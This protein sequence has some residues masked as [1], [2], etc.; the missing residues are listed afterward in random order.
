MAG[1]S[2]FDISRFNKRYSELSSEPSTPHSSGSR[3]FSVQQTLGAERVLD[4]RILK[5]LKDV[6]GAA[7]DFEIEVRLGKPSE[8]EDTLERLEY[9]GWIV[10]DLSSGKKIVRL[11]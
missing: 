2:K 3:G 9:E 5:L 6:G 4:G 11:K 8:L 7:T 1:R 10:Q